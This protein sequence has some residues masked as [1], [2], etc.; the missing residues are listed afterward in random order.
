[1]LLVGVFKGIF[2]SSQNNH[3]FSFDMFFQPPY[4][5]AL[6]VQCLRVLIEINAR[7]KLFY[8]G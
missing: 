7:D 4:C 1:M 5:G 2:A 8:D 3:Q 6:A